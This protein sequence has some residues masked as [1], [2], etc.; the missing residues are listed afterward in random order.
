MKIIELNLLNF[1][2]F[3]NKKINFEEGLNLFYGENE[4]GKTTIFKF[5]EGVFYGFAKS[6]LRTMRTTED[7]DLY[8]PWDSGEYQGNII[9][10]SHE[11][12]YRLFRDF[13][14]KEYFLYDE[15]TGK[16]IG[17][18]LEGYSRSNISFPGEYFFGIG[19]ELFSKVFVIQEDLLNMEHQTKE[20]LQDQLTQHSAKA[21]EAF[22]AFSSLQYL[23][24]MKNEIGTRKA[25]RKPLGSLCSEKE[26]LLAKIEKF[27]EIQQ[28]YKESIASLNH[29]EKQ[30]EVLDKEYSLSKTQSLFEE[31]NRLESAYQMKLNLQEELR[32]LQQE[33]KISHLLNNVTNDEVEEYIANLHDLDRIKDDYDRISLSKKN[34]FNELKKINYTIHQNKDVELRYERI[35]EI[36]DSTNS[37]KRKGRW[38]IMGLIIPIIGMLIAFQN[39][40]MT[41]FYGSVLLLLLLLLFLLLITKNRKRVNKDLETS[42]RNLILD[43][44]L[45][46]ISPEELIQE[47]IPSSVDTASE[48]EYLLIQEQIEDFDMRIDHL[49][50]QEDEKTE[51]LREF[52]FKINKVDIISL[53]ELDNLKRREVSVNESIDSKNN[54]LKQIDNEFDFNR[55][56]YL[57]ELELEEK[58]AEKYET[59]NEKVHKNNVDISALRERISFLEP[60]L[61]ELL[62][63]SERIE[64]LN[65]KISFFENKRKG[66]E[67]AIE[68]INLAKNNI[69]KNYIPR[70]NHMLSTLMTELRGENFTI[71]LGDQFELSIL[72]S[73]GNYIDDK[74]LSSGTFDQ[75]MILIRLFLIEEIFEDSFPLILD[76]AFIRAD[77]HRL[78]L[79]LDYLLEISSYRQILLFTCQQRERELLEEK[80]KNYHSI[81]L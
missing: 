19:S 47:Y 44:N 65:E 27:D 52:L 35:K 81:D 39:S 18:D 31:R 51:K 76:D 66:I 37:L 24:N 79:L 64:E 42:T 58:D 25:K 34:A 57:R 43:Y 45:P 72:N 29:L 55:L 53:E 49:I 78:S 67:L 2:K 56:E 11:K 14:R 33:I 12:R 68:C 69:F 20:I 23:L 10:E 74:S 1:G 8:Y 15:L 54:L 30:R 22:S 48:E 62:E 75:I 13:K 38:I 61:N 80:G 60:K 50:L 77:N 40:Q 28:Q 7:Y 21:I 4:S 26:E 63:A 16:D 70:M 6:Y 59:I 41:F 71:K 36:Y 9:F 32:A 17:E 5:I 73:Q 46:N 3:C